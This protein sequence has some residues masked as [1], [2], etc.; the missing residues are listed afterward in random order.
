MPRSLPLAAALE[1]G[2]VELHLVVVGVVANDFHPLRLHLAQARDRH[3]DAAPVF[4]LG[5][6]APPRQRPRIRRSQRAPDGQ[7]TAIHG[8]ETAAFPLG[9]CPWP[10]RDRHRED[11]V[12]VS[13]FAP[14]V[15][16]KLRAQG[17]RLRSL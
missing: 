16:A 14:D 1:F 10:N 2:Q 5:N 4:E 9:H 11:P 15:L 6:L 17:G 12:P 3:L 8:P 13:V 7:W